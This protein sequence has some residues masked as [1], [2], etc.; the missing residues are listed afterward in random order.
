M[1]K[2]IIFVF[3]EIKILPTRT[4]SEFEKI[5]MRTPILYILYVHKNHI[6]VVYFIQK[7]NMLCDE[8]SVLVKIIPKN[9]NLKEKW[10]KVVVKMTNEIQ[11][12]SLFFRRSVNHKTVSEEKNGKKMVKK[13]KKVSK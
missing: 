7:H 4:V 5:G 11:N 2:I 8:M 1:Q 13:C 10:D 3:F 9:T 6:F 12:M